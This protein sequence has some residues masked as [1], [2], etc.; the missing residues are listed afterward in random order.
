MKLPNIEKEVTF[1]ATKVE[2]KSKTEYS[3]FG[4]LSEGFGNAVFI[5]N[6]YGFT[7]AI[8]VEEKFYTIRSLGEG[9]MVLV[10][11]DRKKIK[12][13]TVCLSGEKQS[14]E[15]GNNEN[16]RKRIS[17]EC[18]DFDIRILFVHTP[19]GGQTQAM[20]DI[21]NTSLVQLQ[22][23]L[24]NSQC[25][26]SVMMAGVVEIGSLSETSNIVDDLNALV[27]SGSSGDVSTWIQNTQA[28]LVV[29]LSNNSYSGVLG[30]ANDIPGRFAVVSA[31]T[32][33]STRTF[34]HEVAHL[35]NSRHQQSSIYDGGLCWTFG[36]GDNTFGA[37]HG[38]GIYAN[39]WVPFDNTKRY[40]KTTEHTNVDFDCV[41]D[42]DNRITYT[43]NLP[44]FQTQI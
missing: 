36:L 23:T 14:G 31:Q 18:Q 8:E 11:H 15:K 16:K 12:E 6:K 43:E 19:A 35:L 37:N 29:M 5:S 22:Q 24:S 28:D 10:E 9:Q 38:Y 41:F 39:R 26:V 7:G 20:N 44:F 2:A 13:K 17:S 42:G 27:N 4:N 34:P 21:A 32:T 3:W 40:F 30:R 33:E 25:N 1:E